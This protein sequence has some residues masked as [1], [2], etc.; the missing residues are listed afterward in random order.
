MSKLG[1]LAGVLSAL[2]LAVAA[3]HNVSPE[4]QIVSN[5]DGE[6]QSLERQHSEDGVDWGVVLERSAIAYQNSTAE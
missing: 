4:F 5:A 1:I 3:V 2:W 6:L